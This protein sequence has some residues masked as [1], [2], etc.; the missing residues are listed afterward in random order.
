[1]FLMFN[2]YNYFKV[3][4][5]ILFVYSGL[6]KWLPISLD[7][8][9]LTG[10]MCAGIFF[11]DVISAKKSTN[12]SNTIEYVKLIFLFFCAWYLST[13]LYTSSENFWISKARSI[14][15]LICAFY[16]PLVSLRNISVKSI[17]FNLIF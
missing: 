8:T 3:F 7:I 13:A 15:L 1:M 16:F 10:L 6:F 2:Y 12:K 14:L 5:Y 4:I 9:L 11:F 17:D